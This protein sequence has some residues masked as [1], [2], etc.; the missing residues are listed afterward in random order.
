M[1][2]VRLAVWLQVKAS[3]WVGVL[4]TLAATV[5]AGWSLP[6]Y[7]LFAP[8]APAGDPDE[9]TARSPALHLAVWWVLRA[10]ALPFA[11]AQETP[12]ERTL[13]LIDVEQRTLT[14]LM[15]GEV[16]RTY[17]CAVGKPRTPT[18]VGE[19]KVSSK[20]HN[21]GGGFGT[22]WLGLN[23]PWGIYGIH[24]T[25][26]N[27]SIGRNVSG[28]CVRMFNHD[29][30]E[31]FELVRVGTPVKI[32]GPEPAFRPRPVYEGKLTGRDVVA[33]QLRL[34]EAGFSP[35]WADGRLGP[36]T[37]RAIR[38]LQTFYG[39]AVDGRGTPSVQQIVGFR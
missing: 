8:A 34:K 9:L 20:S 25:N 16:R 19:W 31:L 5:L 17:P 11:A 32:V 2:R 36:R 23:V 35:Q 3:L 7:R 21:W 1:R 22:R 13:I 15:D 29:V 33:F 27:W 30:E 39:L 18:P 26:K 24:G 12:R 28:G 6:E 38:E 14:V 37:E 4:S 10:Q